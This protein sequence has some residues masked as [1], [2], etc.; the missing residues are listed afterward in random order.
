MS[1]FTHIPSEIRSVLSK[2][3]YSSVIEAVVSL[4]ESFRFNDKSF[5]GVKR[6]NCQL[7]NSQLFQLLVLLPFFAVKGFSH[8]G[9]SA[10]SR[11]F[12]GEK[13]LLYSFAQQDNIDWR[14][15]V[16]RIAGKLISKTI[17]R[18]D[19]RKSYLPKV[20]IVDDTDLRKS[21]KRIENIGFI[22]SHARNQFILGFKALM[23]C[24]SDGISQYMLDASLHGEQGGVS[25]KKQGLTSEERQKRFRREREEGCCTAQRES[26]LFM[27][28]I[29]KLIEMV[30]RAIRTGVPFDYLLVDS[31]F[32][33]TALLKLVSRSRRK[34]HLLGMAKLG[35]TKYMTEKWRELTAKAIIKKLKD[36]NEIKYS[37]KLH[38][39]YGCI[40]VALD[41]YKVRLFLIR[42]GKKGKWRVLL[43]TDRS[44]DFLRAYEIYA[45]RWSIEVFF[46]DSKRILYLEKCSA[47]DFSSQIAH[48]SLVMIRYNLLSMVKRL[49]D[50]ETIGGL[51]KD[52]YYGVHELTVV[53]KIWDI[54]IEIISIVA[55]LLGAEE[56][57]LITQII[58]NSE[59]LEALRIYAKAS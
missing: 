29:D 4:F 27:S 6:E 45:M 39:Y 33:C 43:T 11:M 55:N 18:E 10:L 23:L 30:R 17:Y 35:N 59:R 48:I 37:R 8:Y 20:L 21:G 1:K 47:T 51:Y 26:E 49:H 12:G 41:R 56:E 24:W 31:W 3:C 7:R 22:F 50:Y 15:I 16:Y 14:G 58:D 34:F 40:D 54:I 28:K 53:E 5:G 42:Q 44:L 19:S 9:A 36:A 25:G 46:S 52:V 32:T 13:S 57:D 2:K 38:C